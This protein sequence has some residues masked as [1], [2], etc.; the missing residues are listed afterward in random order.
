MTYQEDGSVISQSAIDQ[1]KAREEKWS[2]GQQPAS[3]DRIPTPIVGPEKDSGD[4]RQTMSEND[5]QQRLEP[6][7]IDSTGRSGQRTRQF[8]PRS[9]DTGGS[10]VKR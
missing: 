4:R 7:Q 6:G 3:R 5:G 2:K 9:T 8:D 1:E 10:R